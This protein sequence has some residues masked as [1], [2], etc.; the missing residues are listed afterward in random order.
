MSRSHYNSLGE[1]GASANGSRRGRSSR[2][3][4]SAAGIVA[5]LTT[6]IGEMT[7]Y[8]NKLERALARIGTAADTSDFRDRLHDDRTS[9]TSLVKDLLE[10]LRAAQPE[11]DAKQFTRLQLQFEAQYKKY[12]K[13]QAQLD[14]KQRA[15][16]SA[17]LSDDGPS[18][19]AYPTN[20]RDDGYGSTAGRVQQQVQEEEEEVTFTE[21]HHE[22][23]V[24]RVEEIKA[25]EG[26]VAEV[27]ELYK[28]LHALVHEQQEAI[29]VVSEN[30]VEAK[31]QVEHAQV[32]LEA[33][34]TQQKKAR[35]R[36]CCVA[37]IVV[38]CIAVAVVVLLLLRK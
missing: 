1:N 10:S 14:A 24:R 30:V 6:S 27:A 29:D 8:N 33:A 25:I 7:K 26:E 15:L 28:D 19:S 22:E 23:V 11:L 4:A 12:N 37:L 36:K 38:A 9:F 18:S 16:L 21:W 35:T 3:S 34:A 5:G 13:L 32:Q 20:G 17:H 2:A 31:G